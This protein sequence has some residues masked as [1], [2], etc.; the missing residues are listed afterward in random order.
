EII[1]GL[2]RIG[3]EVFVLP[4]TDQFVSLTAMSRRDGVA[5]GTSDNRRGGK[6]VLVK[7]LRTGVQHQFAKTCVKV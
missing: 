7:G 5:I 3:H 4:P 1:E 6:V 2:S